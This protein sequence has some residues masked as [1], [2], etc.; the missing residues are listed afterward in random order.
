MLRCATNW[1]GS[2][3]SRLKGHLASFGGDGLPLYRMMG[4]QMGW[5]GKDGEESPYDRSERRVLGSMSVQVAAGFTSQIAEPHFDL[6]ASIELLQ[7]SINV[8]LQMQTGEMGTEDAPE[9]WWIWGPAQAINVGDG[10]HALARMSTFNAQAKGLSTE[11]TIAAVQALDRTALTFYEGQYLDLTLQERVDITTKQ[12][13]GMAEKRF[14]SLWAGAF[15]IGAIGGSAPIEAQ[16][17]LSGAGANLGVAI[18]IQRDIQE[19]WGSER[20]PGR[21]LSKSK[22]YPVAYGFEHGTLAQKRALGESYFKRVIEPADISHIVSVLESM[23]AREQAHEKMGEYLK[24]ATDVL[25][26]YSTDFEDIQA[27]LNGMLAGDA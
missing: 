18:Q 10:L 6:A 24:S 5:I 12:Y 22:T 1:G 3:D 27:D 19:L 9:V 15:E 17:A 23:D 7:E 8:H 21:L 16:A 2:I 13:L 26:T 4:Y 20:P 25:R 14:G 11:R